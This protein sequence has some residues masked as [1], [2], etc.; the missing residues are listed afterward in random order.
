MTRQRL[1]P[2]LRTLSLAVLS[3][4]AAQANALCTL[5]GSGQPSL[6]GSFSS[7]LGAGTLNATTAC[8]DEGDD[9]AWTSVGSIGQIDIVLELAGAAGVTT[10]GIYDLNDPNS[11]LSVFERIASVPLPTPVLLLISGL[12]GLAGVSRPRFFRG[13]RH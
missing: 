3:L 10:F 1:I 2:T 8:V 4:G 5:G 6:Q 12:V 7:P 13:G 9:A 11:Q